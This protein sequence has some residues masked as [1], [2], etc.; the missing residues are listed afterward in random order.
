MLV[1]LGRY[2]DLSQWATWRNVRE[3]KGCK[4]HIIV[5][6]CQWGLVQYTDECRGKRERG[7]QHLCYRE[8]ILD[9]LKIVSESAA[10]VGN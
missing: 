1:D 9:V 8:T 4:G 6:L 10:A 5:E 3:A 2:R 7:D